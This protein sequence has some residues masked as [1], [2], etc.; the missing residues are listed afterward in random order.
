MVK[1]GKTRFNKM[2][3]GW[4]GNH[5][6]LIEPLSYDQVCAIHLYTT[7]SLYKDLR[8]DIAKHEASKWADYVCEL[9]VGIN[10]LPMV[11]KTT[12]RG[13]SQAYVDNDQ[14][15]FDGYNENNTCTTMGWYEFNII[16]KECCERIC[17]NKKRY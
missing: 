6:K 9:V 5:S 13:I 8:R 11:W 7:D 12:F 4:F 17:R 3:N 14:N 15:F 10:K 1:A 16:K 2:Q